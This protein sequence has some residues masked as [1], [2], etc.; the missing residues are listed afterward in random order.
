MKLFK[1]VAAVAVLS[2]PA[3]AETPTEAAYLET[4]LGTWSTEAQSVSEDYDW[5]G[6]QKWRIMPE[7]DSGVWVYQENTIFGANPEAEVSED[8][9]PY[10]QVAVHF[11][12]LGDGLL[13]TTTHRVA[14]R[15]SAR[16]FAKGERETFD[17]AWLGEIACMG[18]M[19]QIGQGYWTGSASCPNGYK[20]GVKVE[21]RSIFAPG[22][23]INWDRGFNA[24]GEH[25]WGPASG[26]YI[27][28]KEEPTE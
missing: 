25:I 9:A 4:A 13:H 6:S 14:D 23:F 19:Q 16:A 5:V 27:F 17:K 18:R 22:S 21:S 2:A 24:A 1:L 26:G 7:A 12:D 15:A 8:P 3:F 28:E 11:R 10:F 20:G